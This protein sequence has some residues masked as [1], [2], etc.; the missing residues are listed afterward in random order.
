MLPEEAHSQVLALANANRVSTAWVI[1]MAVQRL[2]DEQQGQLEL[3][4]P[5]SSRK[6]TN[7]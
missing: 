4:L 2:L 1:R 5:L 3:P 6:G 7:Q